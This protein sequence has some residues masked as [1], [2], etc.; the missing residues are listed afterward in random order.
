MLNLRVATYDK[1]LGGYVPAI[2]EPFWV[3]SW[4]TWFQA[5]PYC[6]RCKLT[7]KKRKEWDIHY[8]LTHLEEDE[9]SFGE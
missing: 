2:P 7:F 9:Q 1:E 3:W 6:H 4:R 5:R 8:V